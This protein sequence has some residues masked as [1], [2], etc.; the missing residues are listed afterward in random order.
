MLVLL[1]AVPLERYP[2]KSK[3]VM[4][5][6]D[7][8][9]PEGTSVNMPGIIETAA[10]PCNRRLYEFAKTPMVNAPTVF[11]TCAGS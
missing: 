2:A 5:D 6:P 9:R 1:L 3:P 7:D 8:A 10:F 4:I 11:P